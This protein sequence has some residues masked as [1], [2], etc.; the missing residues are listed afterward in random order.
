MKKVF[1]RGWEGMGQEMYKK[2]AKPTNLRD[3]N[4]SVSIA[5][6]INPC[7]HVWKKKKSIYVRPIEPE[8]GSQEQM[9][10]RLDIYK[11]QR[12]IRNECEKDLGPKTKM[13][14]SRCA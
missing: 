5:D 12:H 6:T 9:P 13:V 7:N 14:Y 10:R 11:S 3:F 4:Q 8:E 2:E 1:Q